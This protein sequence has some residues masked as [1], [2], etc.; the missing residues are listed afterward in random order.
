MKPENM[1]SKKKKKTVT[2]YHIL[3]YAIPMKYTE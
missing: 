2:K 1:L 3:Y